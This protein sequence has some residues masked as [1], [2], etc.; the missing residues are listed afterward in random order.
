M[1]SIVF[2]GKG[3]IFIFIIVVVTWIIGVT[4]GYKTGSNSSKPKY[5]G[6]IF[7]NANATQGDPAFRCQVNPEFIEACYDS[8]HKI[9]Y[10]IFKVEDETNE[11]NGLL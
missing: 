11:N 6:K 2:D 9:K 1:G 3:L 4:L 7:V 5:V 10:V 8:T